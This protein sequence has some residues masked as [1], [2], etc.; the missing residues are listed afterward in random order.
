M[1][2][3]VSM[4]ADPRSSVLSLPARRRTGPEGSNGK[5]SQ[6]RRI[7]VLSYHSSPLT[8]PGAGDSGGMTIYVRQLAESLTSL[9]VATDIFTRAAEAGSRITRLSPGVRVIPI[10]AGPRRRL[11]KEALSAY[12][13]DFAIG[14][15]AFSLAQR[16]G[17][18][19]IHS[20]Y[21]QS[22]LA[23]KS[24]ASA[25]NVPLVH[26]HHT[27]GR[28]KNRFLAPDDAPESQTRLD[29]EGEVIA[30]ADVLIA[31]TDAE[32][33][34]LACLYGAPH[35]LLKTIHP[36]VDHEIFHPGDR[37]AA[38]ASLGLSDASVV[39]YVG[40][41]QPLKGLELA[42]RAVEQLVPAS[43]RR[44][45]LLIV[46]GASGRQGDEEVRRLRQLADDLGIADNVVFLGAQ[47][48][49]KLPDIYRAADV[50]VVCSHSE[51]FGLA[52]LE[53]HACGTPVVGTPVGGL[54]YIVRD[55]SSGYLIDTRDPAVFAA[56]LK[57]LLADEDLQR[58]F[59]VAALESAKAFSWK[60]SAREFLDLY[61]CLVREPLSHVCTC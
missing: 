21:W 50:L 19:L 14:I 10:D 51:S 5:G 23:G 26:S 17:Y 12:I 22:G 47:P 16:V 11:D 7:A 24:L 46:G 38:R 54:S 45:V 13:E 20:H 57:T 30:A 27:L 59:R 60:E 3:D 9:G 29:G 36:G 58:E 43:D 48:H 33:Q 39:A 55:G 44:V 25:W 8:E 61:D 4:A 41:I 6:V 56:R 32:W 35:D 37:D 52:A 53:A 49:D 2:V 34:H 1:T 40:R 18:D 28:V 31:S 15:R 42:V